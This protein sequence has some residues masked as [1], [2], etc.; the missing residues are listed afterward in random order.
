MG[1]D[2]TNNDS[3]I[4]L[5]SPNTLPDPGISTSIAL[6]DSVP[7]SELIGVDSIQPVGE[8]IELP[9][10]V[11]QDESVLTEDDD[12]IEIPSQIPTGENVLIDGVTL[13]DPVPPTQTVITGDKYYVHN[14]SIPNDVWNVYHNLQ[15]RPAIHIEDSTGQEII[16]QIVHVTNNYLRVYFGKPYVGTAHCN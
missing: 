8:I 1:Y 14:Q 4:Q 5:V 6:P 7:S 2:V 11:L 16:T 10:N 3:V 9:D 13:T 15:K 12:A